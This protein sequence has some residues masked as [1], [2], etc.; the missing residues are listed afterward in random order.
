METK[1]KTKV[2]SGMATFTKTMV[3]V[4]AVVGVAV[5]AI[6]GW[7]GSLASSFISAPTRYPVISNPAYDW[8]NTITPQTFRRVSGTI[9]ED[10]L[11]AG[12]T[13][14][15][16][17][18][19][20][21][22]NDTFD[23][24]V[25]VAVTSLRTTPGFDVFLKSVVDTTR[26]QKDIRP[27]FVPDQIRPH[28]WTISMV[29]TM[30]YKSNCNEPGTGFNDS[31]F[32]WGDF[33]A[34]D[35]SISMTL[36][37]NNVTPTRVIDMRTTNVYR[38]CTD[39]SRYITSYDFTIEATF[40]PAVGS[41]SIYPPA[42]GYP[43]V[44][45]S[46]SVNPLPVRFFPIYSTNSIIK[47]KIGSTDAGT[48]AP[49]C[50]DAAAS[51]YTIGSVLSLPITSPQVIKAI[52]CHKYTAGGPFVAVGRSIA[53]GYS[54]TASLTASRILSPEIST[55]VIPSAVLGGRPSYQVSVTNYDVQTAGVIRMF[56]S[57]NGSDPT[58]G[59]GRELL[60]PFTDASGRRVGRFYL[61]YPAETG[62]NALIRVKACRGVRGS[63]TSLY[64]YTAPTFVPPDLR[65][66]REN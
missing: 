5:V 50:G 57:V 49:T 22:A 35:S 26:L 19:S 25:D 54:Y 47:Y 27:S 60:L 20:P 2:T 33:S 61:T 4:G 45:G 40:N 3:L 17:G 38:F 6:A 63:D 51:E 46:Y 37:D 58:C 16:I 11:P 7:G 18:T 24:R 28:V 62:P 42:P 8:T 32:T 53:A 29:P 9:T 13:P 64:T 41:L 34:L 36:R 30:G 14:L 39:A 21:V 44:F 55:A 23:T 66:S 10:R 65:G 56:Y 52:E 12:E 48:T 31:V 43:S 59:S 1:Q 15:T